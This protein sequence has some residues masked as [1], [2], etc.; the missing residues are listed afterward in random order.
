LV[1]DTKAA[2]WLRRLFTEPGPGRIVAMDS[3]RALF[4][5]QLRHLV[6][7][8]DQF[9]RTPW[10]GAPIRHADHPVPRREQGTTDEDNAQGLCEACNYVKDAPGWSVAATSSVGRH[11]VTITAP[12]PP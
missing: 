7:L 1:R 3:R 5:G 6:V 8:R 4:E 10:C 2:V 12:R 9:C 11:V